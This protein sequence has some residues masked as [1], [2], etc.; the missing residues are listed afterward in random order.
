M[1]GIKEHDY[2]KVCAELASCLSIS[3]SAASKRVDIAAARKG[4]KDLS[5]RKEIAAALSL[6]GLMSDLAREYLYKFRFLL[7][8]NECQFALRVLRDCCLEGLLQ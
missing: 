6:P 5:S 2:L 4:A 3:I 8:Q 7:F 1:A